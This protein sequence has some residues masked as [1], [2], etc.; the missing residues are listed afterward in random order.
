VLYALLAAVFIMIYNHTDNHPTVNILK[1]KGW[2]V[3]EVTASKHKNKWGGWWIDTAI[4][5]DTEHRESHKVI[6]GTFL[7][8]TLK[9]ALYTLRRNDFPVNGG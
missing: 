2:K 6:D 3:F 8:V 1:R 5:Y 7:G 4:A 9:D